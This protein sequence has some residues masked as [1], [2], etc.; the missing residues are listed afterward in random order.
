MKTLFQNGPYCTMPLI[1][2]GLTGPGGRSVVYLDNSRPNIR[3]RKRSAAKQTLLDRV[4][5]GF[6]TRF[7]IGN[8]PDVKILVKRR[9][10]VGQSI[11]SNNPKCILPDSIQIAIQGRYDNKPIT[12]N[13]DGTVN[14]PNG[15]QLTSFSFC[16]SNEGP[17]RRRC[18]FY[19]R[20]YP[21]HTVLVPGKNGTL[22]RH[23]MQIGR[24]DTGYLDGNHLLEYNPPSRWGPKL[25]LKNN[26]LTIPL[27]RSL[28]AFIS[29]I[30]RAIKNTAGAN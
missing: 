5:W 15:T 26:E 10:N 4:I 9:A 17:D 11:F 27:L 24:V 13:L 21:E 23:S 29:T 16:R 14:E 7:E 20:I 22:I 28:E 12:L 1:P 25:V 3:V 18:L 19:E 30:E 6:Q 8:Q 2:V